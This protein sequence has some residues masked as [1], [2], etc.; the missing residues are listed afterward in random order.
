MEQVNNSVINNSGDKNA[1]LPSVLKKFNWG[2]FLLSFIWGI[3]NKSYITLISLPIALLPVLGN[4]INLGLGIWY[5]VKGNE[6]A[7]QNKRWTDINNFNRV[8]KI[9]VGAGL[10][11][12]IL[13]TFLSTVNTTN[14]L[15]NATSSV[16]SKV[17]CKTAA[18][19]LDV[20]MSKNDVSRYNS[21]K[22]LVGMFANEFNNPQV[23]NNIIKV[24]GF[25]FAINKNGQCA[26]N[27]TNCEFKV[28]TEP[29]VECNYYLYDGGKYGMSEGTK[30]LIGK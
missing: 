1:Q 29:Q 13:L 12:F 3:G 5:G 8:Q 24:N 17:K 11:I 30:T 21:T 7:W 22:E 9:W 25:T 19:Y 2:A 20:I 14:T 27:S 16:E 4:L 26:A 18:S 28:I 10:V 6:W 15:M 23:E